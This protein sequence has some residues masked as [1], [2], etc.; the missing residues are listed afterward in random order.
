MGGF[1]PPHFLGQVY[2]YD[3]RLVQQIKKLLQL[4]SLAQSEV[5]SGSWQEAKKNSDLLHIESV[6][7]EIVLNIYR[8]KC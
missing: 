7:M 2:A 4:L 3:R 1:G 5:I 8:R 6:C